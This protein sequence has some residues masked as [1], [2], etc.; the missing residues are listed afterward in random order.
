MKITNYIFIVIASLLFG[1]GLIDDKTNSDNLIVFEKTYSPDS[2]KYLIRYSYD[3]GALGSCCNQTSI[4]KETD[5]LSSVNDFI[6]PSVFDNPTWTD[7]NQISVDIHMLQLLKSK[8]NFDPT[9]P[10][11]KIDKINDISIQKKYSNLITKTD[12]ENIIFSKRSPNQQLI[13]IGYEYEA[14]EGIEDSVLHISVLPKD[15]KIPDY[16][17]LYIITSRMYSQI[18]SIDWITNDSIN[19]TI[20]DTNKNYKQ[21]DFFE[22]YRTASYPNITKG[23]KK[24]VTYK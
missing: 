17:N 13:L 18:E 16:G 22:I 7:D 2:L 19:I 3:E 6:I 14:N 9:F 11:L 15:E 10:N 20:W 12:Q 5:S 1:C 24:K 8:G 23:I 21:I 4:L